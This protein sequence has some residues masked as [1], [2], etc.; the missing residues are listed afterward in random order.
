MAD[1]P[2]QTK[3]I[4]T[5]ILWSACDA[6]EKARL[7]IE[8]ACTAAGSKAIVPVDLLDHLDGVQAELHTHICPDCSA[9]EARARHVPTGEKVIKPIV[10]NRD[11]PN[12]GPNAS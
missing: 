3:K 4:D 9:H 2:V 5:D 7:W 1:V 8:A 11:N 6:L 10:F 12:G